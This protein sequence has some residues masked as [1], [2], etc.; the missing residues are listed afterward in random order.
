MRYNECH[1]CF[2]RAFFVDIDGGDD[3]GGGDADDDD[4]DVE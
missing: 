4:D 3:D 2:K 1:R